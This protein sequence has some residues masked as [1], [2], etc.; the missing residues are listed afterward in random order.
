MKKTTFADIK[1]NQKVNIIT[2]KA[3][4]KVKGGIIIVGDI[5]GG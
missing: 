5:I 2:P 3:Q 1:K 4:K